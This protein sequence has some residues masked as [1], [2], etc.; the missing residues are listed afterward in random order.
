MDSDTGGIWDHTVSGRKSVINWQPRYSKAWH[1]RTLSK[2][3]TNVLKA[4]Q[5]VTVTNERTQS[6][7]ACHGDWLAEHI[8]LWTT[9]SVLLTRVVHQES[10]LL[11]WLRLSARLVN[12]DKDLITTTDAH[13]QLSRVKVCAPKTQ[14]YKSQIKTEITSLT[15]YTI[16]PMH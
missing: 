15:V 7:T 10:K 9:S 8:R 11:V 5:H 6:L 12:R 2:N 1:L 4:L 13:H 16:T 3:R 14:P